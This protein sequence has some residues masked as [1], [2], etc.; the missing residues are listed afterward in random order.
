MLETHLHYKKAQQA[1]TPVV[2]LEN[3]NKNK[4][5]DNVKSCCYASV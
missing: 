3:G 2:L 1:N 5:K 4:I